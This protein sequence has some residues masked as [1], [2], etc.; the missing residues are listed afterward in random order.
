MALGKA[1]VVT[2]V[3]GLPEVVEDGKD[4][5][6][7]PAADPGALAS[8]II[9]LLGDVDLRNRLGLAARRRAEAFDVRASVRRAEDAYKELAG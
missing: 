6:L 9:E 5:I 7:V 4:G 8:R 1:V 3:G 2:R